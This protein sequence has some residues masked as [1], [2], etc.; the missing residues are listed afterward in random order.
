M[1]GDM[2]KDVMR[3]E[4]RACDGLGV[5]VEKGEIK[6]DTNVLSQIYHCLCSSLMGT[7]NCLLSSLIPGTAER[8]SQHLSSKNL[9][10]TNQQFLGSV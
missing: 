4:A 6:E 7:V 5:L 1:S 2:L 10:S 3:K 8:K 9:Q